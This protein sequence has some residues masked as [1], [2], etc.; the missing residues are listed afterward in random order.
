MRR[1]PDDPLWEE[2]VIDLAP[3]LRDFADTADL[4][5]QLDLLISVDTSVV[6]LAGAMAKPAWV[7]LPYAPDWRW[8]REREDSPWY[9]SLRLFRQSTIGD[10][11]PVI[12]AV[13]ERLLCLAQAGVAKDR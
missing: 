4:L 13:S 1:R 11:A 2:G 10:W 8:L 6:H 3:R 5:D 9:S 12:A 7:L